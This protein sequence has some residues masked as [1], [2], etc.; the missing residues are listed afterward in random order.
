ML[1][2]AWRHGGEQPYELYNAGVQDLPPHPHPDRLRAFK[3]AMGLAADEVDLVL[4]GGGPEG[5]LE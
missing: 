5:A 1:F 3:Y 4:A 2:Q